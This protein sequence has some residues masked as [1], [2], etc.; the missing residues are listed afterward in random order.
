MYLLVTLDHGVMDRGIAQVV[1][2]TVDEIFAQL[3]DVR[4]HSFLPSLESEFT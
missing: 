4:Y 2:G 3:I 1:D